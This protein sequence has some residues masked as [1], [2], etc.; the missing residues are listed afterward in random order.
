MP[1]ERQS[2]KNVQPTVLSLTKHHHDASAP[3]QCNRHCDHLGVF[4]IFGEE[5]QIALFNAFC[6]Q[7]GDRQFHDDLILVCSER[8]G[9]LDLSDHL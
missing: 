3:G 8:F 2:D 7:L 6:W 1:V 9:L 5:R 4:T